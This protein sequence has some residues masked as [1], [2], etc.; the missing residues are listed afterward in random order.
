LFRSDFISNPGSD[1]I[2]CS[3][4]VV[5]D[6]DFVDRANSQTL[7][8]FFRSSGNPAKIQYTPN[9]LTDKKTKVFCVGYENSHFL[10]TPSLQNQSDFIELPPTSPLLKKIVVFLNLIVGVIHARI[11]PAIREKLLQH[12]HSLSVFLDEEYDLSLKLSMQ[13]VRRLFN[14]IIN[15]FG[16]PL[17]KPNLI[18]LKPHLK[19]LAK[20]TSNY[21]KVAVDPDQEPDFINA[22]QENSALI[23]LKN[24]HLD[25]AQECRIKQIKSHQIHRTDTFIEME[26]KGNNFTQEIF[27]LDDNADVSNPNLKELTLSDP[28]YQLRAS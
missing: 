17:L 1:E 25:D 8:I 10:Q 7:V 5:K 11:L 22:R 23:C 2:N 15:F 9:Q 20:R 26:T 16:P 6:Y 27:Y 3:V 24:Q 12:I 4:S 18:R 14:K 13:I 28:V 21:V 19:K